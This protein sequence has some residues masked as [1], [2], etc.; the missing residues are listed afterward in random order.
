MEYLT[1]LLAMVAGDV[2]TT[3]VHNWPYLRPVERRS[4]S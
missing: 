3:I 2:W 4:R 1:N